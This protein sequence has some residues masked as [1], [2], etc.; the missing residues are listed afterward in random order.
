MKYSIEYQYLPK[1]NTRPC[2]DGEI[3]GI[4]A[5][6]QSGVVILPNVGDFVDINNHSSAHGH[7]SFSGKV[8]TRLFNYLRTPDDEIY[9]HVNIVVEEDPETN[10]GSLLKE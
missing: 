7:E 3:V 5:D 8:K 2:D 1:G 4:K 9:C 6:D 10:W